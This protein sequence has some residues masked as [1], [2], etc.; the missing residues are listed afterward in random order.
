MG[1][2]VNETSKGQVGVS[3]NAKCQALLEDGATLIPTPTKFVE[4]LV[5]VVDNG[6]FTA[7]G[8]AYDQREFDDFSDSNDPRRKRWFVWDKVKEFAG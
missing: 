1:K 7:A 8:Y 5:C 6:F 4:N 3:F 2:Y